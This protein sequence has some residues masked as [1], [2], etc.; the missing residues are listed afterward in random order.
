MRSKSFDGLLA[1]YSYIS[2]QVHNRLDSRADSKT[3]RPTIPQLPISPP[4]SGSNL[5]R[6]TNNP[7][8]DGEQHESAS[9][10][11]SV[12]HERAFGHSFAPVKVA[13]PSVSSMASMI[14]VH[15]HEQ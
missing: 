11:D 8:G 12:E 5:W 13:R 3:S 9:F 1:F 10:S 4:T 6:K 7:A 15:M 2:A 14:I